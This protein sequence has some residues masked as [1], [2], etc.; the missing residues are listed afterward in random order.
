MCVAN[1]TTVWLL[2]LQSDLG[3]VLVGWMTLILQASGQRGTPERQ[4]GSG[5]ALQQDG[6]S[7]A[8]LPPIC[9]VLQHGIPIPKAR[10]SAR[11]HAPPLNDCYL[12]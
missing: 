4:W 1:S 8:P 6:S 7:G 11:S 9:P 3:P 10:I 2:S 12:Y 5:Q